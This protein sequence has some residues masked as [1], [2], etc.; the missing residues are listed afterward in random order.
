[1]KIFER[2]KPG[3]PRPGYVATLLVIL[4]M[5]VLMVIIIHRTR[6]NPSQRL[7]KLSIALSLIAGLNLLGRAA[8]LRAFLRHSR[9]ISADPQSD[10]STAQR[11]E[12]S[13]VLT[14]P[15]TICVFAAGVI[16]ALNF[17]YLISSGATPL[18]QSYAFVIVG[19]LLFFSELLDYKLLNMMLPHSRRG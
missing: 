14:R 2:P 13:P 12:R 5:L 16:L 15:L 8:L 11:N 4:L 7:H 10:T 19:L 17:A 1:M 6:E 9:I 18:D 3:S